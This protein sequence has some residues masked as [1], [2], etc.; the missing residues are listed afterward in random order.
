META[1]AI[2]K[3]HSLSVEI[4]EEL[5]EIDVGNFEGKA[6]ESLK[7]DFST[8]LLQWR[9]GEGKEKLPEGES[10]QDVHNRVWPFAR[11]IVARHHGNVVIASHYFVILV[12]IGAALGLSLVNLKRLRVQ[13]ASISIVDFN[14]DYPY[15]ELL[16]DTCHLKED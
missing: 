16:S 8:F 15:L 12:I 9:G 10:L 14:G 7:S 6:L 5:R 13:P 2:A 11:E 3:Y 1:R 4:R